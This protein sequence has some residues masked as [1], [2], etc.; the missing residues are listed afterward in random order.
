VPPAG[1]RFSAPAP[2]ALAD[3]KTWPTTAALIAEL[4]ASIV[5]ASAAYGIGRT[6]IFVFL[7]GLHVEPLNWQRELCHWKWESLTYVLGD[8]RYLRASSVR[9][10]G[11]VLL[12]LLIAG[13]ALIAA[14]RFDDL[15]DSSAR[16]RNSPVS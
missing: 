12:I 4:P 2:A 15:R 16:C 7:A 13:L 11:L 5:F 8:R 10:L 9:L 1:V 14:E 6:F 3:H